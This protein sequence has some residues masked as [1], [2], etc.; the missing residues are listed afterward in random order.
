MRILLKYPTRGRR[1]TFLSTIQ[2]WVS[3][4][5]RIEAL[6]IAVSLDTDDVSMKDLTVDDLPAVAWK[7]IYRSPN[8][9]KIQACNANLQEV[10][11]PWDIV[12][13]V[14]DD[15]LPEVE[16]W[17]ER[18]RSA[19][20]E[21]LN[22][23]IW[24]HDG[25]Q[26]EKLNTL[27]ILGRRLYDSWG[28]IYHPDYKS[29]YCDNEF[30]DWCKS[31]PSQCTIIPEVLVRHHHPLVTGGTFDALYARN[32]TYLDEDRKTYERRT[33][34]QKMGFLKLLSRR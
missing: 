2:K 24:I 32:Q 31:H 15:M 14:S 4:C 3:T 6:G 7:K 11:W 29:F 1:E 21:S 8:K 22:H 27:S 16:Y 5:H 26:N 12:V 33:A 28:Y 34:P 19:M 17:D 9:T 30:T 25:F 20:P 23:A 18:I 10:E 13:L